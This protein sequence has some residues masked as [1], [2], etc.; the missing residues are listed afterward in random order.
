[1]RILHVADGYPPAT[2]GTERVVEA[3][4][5]NL[6]LK[7]LPTA[8]ATL[9]RPG[10]P[11]SEITDAGVAVHRIDGV[12]RQL[13]RFAADQGHFFHPTFP[14]PLLVRKLQG[15][16]DEFRPDIVHAHGWILSSC[17]S[18]RLDGV[19]LVTTLHDYGLSCAKKTMIPFDRL[20]EQCSGP[21]LRRC[22]G[23]ATQSYGALKGLPITL[24]LRESRRRLD[25]VSMFFP[26]STAV[27]TVSL[28]GVPS[29]RIR[30][31]PSFVDDSVFDAA[32]LTPRPEFLPSGPFLLFVG[33][34]GEHKGLALAAAAHRMMRADLPLVVIG[35]ERT[36]DD[37][38]AS[39]LRPVT[40]FTGIPHDQIMAS[41]AAATAAVVPSRWQEPLGLVAVEAMAAG[42][43]VVVTRVGALPEVV[44]HGETGLV[45]PPNDPAALAAAL[46]ELVRNPMQAAAF[47]AAGRRRARTF[48][49]S[50]V[51]PQFVSAY[52][53]AITQLGRLRTN[54]TA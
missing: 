9:G 12:T 22:L 42:T 32:R 10:S 33:A 24:G 34:P 18:L 16:V 28:P 53:Q 19:A 26:I 13:R 14:D 4:A 21:A 49:A 1:M 52:E 6:A 37:D 43:P 29:E 48:A 17:L 23:C 54:S 35:A 44:S 45:V 36:H 20:D 30:R 8:V 15:L 3:L 38:A 41:F 11:G 25:R 39:A 50:T 27:E 7:G 5:K 40:T 31:I 46:D 47:G 2:G 51:I